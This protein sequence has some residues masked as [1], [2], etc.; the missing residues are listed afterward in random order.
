MGP[1]V[2]FCGVMLCVGWCAGR[3]DETFRDV[4]TKVPGLRYVCS[5]GDVTIR[6]CVCV[7][8]SWCVCACMRVHAYVYM[9]LCVCVCYVHNISNHRTADNNLSAYACIYV[10][11]L[12]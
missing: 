9:C 5:Q 12:N 2:M 8:V 11:S 1:D 3:A 4:R 6:T 10:Q 7:S